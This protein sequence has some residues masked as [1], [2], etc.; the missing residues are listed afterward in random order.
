MFAQAIHNASAFNEDRFQAVNCGAIPRD[1]LQRVNCLGVEG[2]FTGA[3]KK[4]RLGKFEL[5]RGELFFW[6][7]LRESPGCSGKV[8]ASFAREKVLFVSEQI[9]PF[10]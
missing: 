7:K 3:S 1:L 4:G 5:A 10:P 2:A 8:A 6:M 9:E